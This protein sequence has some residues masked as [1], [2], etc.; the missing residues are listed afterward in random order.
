MNTSHTVS[1]EASDLLRLS[2][3]ALADNPVYVLLTDTGTGFSKLSKAIT[4]DPF[5]H[6][7]LALD[8]DLEYVYTYALVTTTNGRRGGLKRES[9]AMLKGARYSLYEMSLTKDMYFK[10]V[11]RLNHLEDNVSQTGYNHWGLVNTLLGKEIFAST[12]EVMICSQFLA[13]VMADA[14]V[15]FFKGRAHS[16]IKPYDFVRSKLLKHVR[17]GTF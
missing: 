10:L 17:R 1:T 9:K 4:G 11:S 13:S 6:V 14:G 12:A 7:S 16:T 15:E 5:N 3:S 8:S 2:K